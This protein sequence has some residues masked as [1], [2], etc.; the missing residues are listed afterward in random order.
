MTIPSRFRAGLAALF[1]VILAACGGG[2]G[3]DGNASP[4]TPD[5]TKPTITVT[6]TV[7]KNDVVL[8]AAVSD[9]V[10]VT[11]VDFSVDG[12]ATKVTLT[13]SAMPS[14]FVTRIPIAQFG[15]GNHSVVGTARDAAKNSTES[16]PALIQVGDAPIKLTITSAKEPGPITFTIDI[17]GAAGTYGIHITIDGV[18]LGGSFSS[19]QH[20]IYTPKNL[21]AG[22]HQ[23]VVGIADDKNNTLSKAV[24]FEI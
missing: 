2:G 24:D 6:V 19:A 18:D 13:D 4:P 23:L 16:A 7:D 8:S 14:T 20:F 17:I 5:T 10:G 9:N 12:G 1:L 21:A 3:T 15:L 11:Q 22:A